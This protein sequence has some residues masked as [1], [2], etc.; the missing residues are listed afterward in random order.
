ME[1]SGGR[2]FRQGGEKEAAG[3]F[4]WAET[5]PTPC[6]PSSYKTLTGDHC[7]ELGKHNYKEK[8]K[9]VSRLATRKERIFLMYLL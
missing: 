4:R 6:F 8:E 9:F 1:P 7:R 5:A 3:T 2:Q